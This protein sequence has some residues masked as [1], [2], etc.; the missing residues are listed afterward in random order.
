MSVVWYSIPLRPSQLS[1][2]HVLKS[3][4]SFRWTAT[5]LASPSSPPSAPTEYSLCLSDRLILLRQSP[6]HLHYSAVF[7]P[8]TQGEATEEKVK[9]TERF[10][11]DYLRLD[12]DLEE[13]YR[14]WGEKDAVFRKEEGDG[15]VL[16]GVAV[17]RQ[18]PWECLFSFICSSNNNIS[19]ITSMVQSAARH[20]SPPL[21]SYPSPPASSSSSSSPSPEPTTYHPFPPPSAFASPSVVPILRDLGFGY[22]AGFIQRTA[23][24]LVEEHVE[25]EEW[26]R[27]LRE[28]ETA[29]AREELLRF[30]GVGRKVADC[31]LLM[32]LDKNDII[33]IDVHVHQ[34]AQRLYN[35]RPSSAALPG[36]KRKASSGEKIPMTPKLYEEVQTALSERWGVWGGWTQAVLFASDLPFLLSSLAPNSTKPLKQPLIRSSQL[37]QPT[38]Y[39]PEGLVALPESMLPSSP[40]PETK[41]SVK[42]EGGGRLAFASSKQ[43]SS[44]SSRKVK[45]GNEVRVKEE[46]KEIGLAQEAEGGEGVGGSLG[47]RIKRRRRNPTT[48]TRGV[49]TK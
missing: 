30:L 13:L 36:G 2:A 12:V 7:P 8:P 18:D 46:V 19:R 49:S 24:M 9:E 32:S 10:V 20:F 28:S 31:V 43:I 35:F 5:P 44:S 29:K 27:E 45:G 34:I 42:V 25:P 38:S 40:P 14:T 22:R 39:L 16:E 15:G 37:P 48:S 21:L 33:P 4:Q 6:T 41:P 11:R 23:A 26:L 17:L 3:G 47:E 1:L